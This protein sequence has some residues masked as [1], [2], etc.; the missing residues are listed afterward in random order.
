MFTEY[1]ETPLG[2]LRLTANETALCRIALV[3]KRGESVPNAVTQEAVLQLSEY[4]LKK[5]EDFSVPL[6]PQGTA[7]QKS[8]WAALKRIPYGKVVTYGQLATAV[9]NAKAVRA[10]ASA[11]GKNPLAL[12]LPC[13]RV[14][15]A[16]GLGGFAWGLA[17]KRTLLRLEG[18]EIPKKSAFS[19]N[20]VHLSMM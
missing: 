9:G 1:L 10:A 16:N 7:F 4:F 2:L 18:V 15:A 5:R 13:H 11:V 20:F 12:I 17:A 8:V 19:E 6:A 14:V 3:E